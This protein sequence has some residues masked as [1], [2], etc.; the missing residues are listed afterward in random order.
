MNP[1]KAAQAL[2]LLR[3]TAAGF[4]CHLNWWTEKNIDGRPPCGERRTGLCQEQGTDPVYRR[5]ARVGW[6]ARR[7]KAGPVR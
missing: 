2:R 1:W 7:A 3:A 5:V 4:R 6:V